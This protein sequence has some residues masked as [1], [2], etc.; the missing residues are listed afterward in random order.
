MTP[1]PVDLDTLKDAI[2]SACTKH[3]R[4]HKSECGSIRRVVTEGAFVEFDSYY[5]L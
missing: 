2:I 4:Y 5:S 3:E 1:A